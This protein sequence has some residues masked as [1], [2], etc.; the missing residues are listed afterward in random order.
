MF[1]L[2]TIVIIVSFLGFLTPGFTGMFSSFS[3]GG[4]SLG[5]V[6]GRKVGFEELRTQSNRNLIAFSLLYGG[7]P[8][9]NNNLSE[10]ASQNAFPAICRIEAAKRRGIKITDQQI[11]DFI[12]KL[13]LFQKKDSKNFDLTLYRNYIDNMLTPNGL[14][15]LELDNSVRDFLV[16]QELNREISESVV[17]TPGE[18]LAFYNSLFEKLD[19]WVG[20][21]NAGDF[22]ATVKVTDTELTKFFEASRKNYTIPAKFQITLISFDYN[23]IPLAPE[24]ISDTAVEKF[25]NENKAIFTLPPTGDENKTPPVTPPLKDIK[26]KVRAELVNKL[27]SGRAIRNAQV[28]ARD[29]Y[30]K[31]G[32]ASAKDQ[33]KIFTAFAT[34]NKLPLVKTGWFDATAEAI[35][36]LKEPELIKQVTGVY[37]QV[38]VTNAVT[39]RKAAYVAFVTERKES[40][41]AEFSEAQAKVRQDV[42]KI[43]SREAA[44]SAARETVKRIAQ[45]KERFKDVKSMTQPKFEKIDTFILSDPPYGQ[46]GAMIAGMAEN[47]KADN[48]SEARDT[49]DGAMLVFVEKR[50]TPASAEFESK[51]QMTESFYRQKKVGAAQ[52]A[53]NSWLDS[54]CQLKGE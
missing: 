36:E 26:A 41:P 31:V 15:A 43:K 28:F 40:R 2:I 27:K 35:D 44:L 10:M 4:S 34:Q 45:S 46:E 11:A 25:Y 22:A 53:F 42:K 9:S 13:P 30:D 51:R 33:Y 32:E 18:V 48:I 21:F 16:Q 54:K 1:G 20:R 7:V 12:A 5:T 39:G 49:E 47:I 3:N 52:S 17:V 6:F 37:E 24:E 50:T 38:P 14:G 8:L 23:S 19:V 29:V